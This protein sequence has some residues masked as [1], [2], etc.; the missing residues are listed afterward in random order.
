MAEISTGNYEKQVY[1]ARELFLK[2]DQEKM[3]RKFALAH[4]AEDGAVRWGE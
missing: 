2:Y 1:I 3:I 4:D